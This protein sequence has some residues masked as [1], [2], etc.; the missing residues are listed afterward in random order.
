MNQTSAK[1]ICGL[2]VVIYAIFIP[3]FF[4]EQ[5]SLVQKFK[6]AQEWPT[7]TGTV[8]K[9]DRM[10]EPRRQHMNGYTVAVEYEY[11]VNGA[12][13]SNV[14][15]T[16]LTAGQIFTNKSFDEKSSADLASRFPAGKK[17]LV[18]YN[19]TMPADSYIDVNISTAAFLPFI[20]FGAVVPFLFL[21]SFGLFSKGRMPVSDK[22][23]VD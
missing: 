21:I 15:D 8:K 20:A 23:Q 11:A 3:K 17:V 9:T 19:K 6:Q 13:F 22:E 18:H 5:Y 12:S 10:A 7:V 1:V 14:Q 4:L 2:L 16:F